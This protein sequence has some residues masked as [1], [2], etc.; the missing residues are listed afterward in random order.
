MCSFMAE[1]CHTMALGMMSESN[2]T[3]LRT[4]A[5]R[6]MRL[7][8]A[9]LLHEM[10]AG[11]VCVWQR[12]CAEQARTTFRASLS[13]LCKAEHARLRAQMLDRS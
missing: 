4:A 13:A 12:G 5:V 11:L 1:E 6:E 3:K 7:I 8:R 2:N 9:R 10:V